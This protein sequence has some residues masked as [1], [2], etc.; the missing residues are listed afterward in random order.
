[1]SIDSKN[2]PRVT[3]APATETT[4]RQK[5]VDSLSR[6]EFHLEDYPELQ[7]RLAANKMLDT[8]KGYT[9]PEAVLPIPLDITEP[10]STSRSTRYRT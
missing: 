4:M 5:V 8:S 7:A 6:E 1:M 2:S 9:L 10:I 3:L